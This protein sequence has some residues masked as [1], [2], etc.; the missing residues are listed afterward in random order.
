M[1]ILADNVGRSN[2]AKSLVD[3]TCLLH[4]V[5][6]ID[7][8]RFPLLGLFVGEVVVEYL[9]RI[10]DD[11]TTAWLDLIIRRLATKLLALIGLW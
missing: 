1:V 2:V 4:R 11:K 5:R 10:P 7:D 3:H 8:F 9:G 6:L